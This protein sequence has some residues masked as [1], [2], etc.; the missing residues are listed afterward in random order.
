MLVISGA[1]VS[2]NNAQ[3][4]KHRWGRTQSYRKRAVTWVLTGVRED[5]KFW[6]DFL[7]SF[8]LCCCS[9][10]KRQWYFQFCTSSFPIYV[11]NKL[12]TVKP[13]SSCSCALYRITAV[14]VPTVKSLFVRSQHAV[15]VLTFWNVNADKGYIVWLNFCSTR[16]RTSAVTRS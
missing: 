12:F 7:C 13:H 5:T 6:C 15:V 16:H 2:L 4:V 8:T 9:H 1:T 14:F 3:N 10:W 11:F